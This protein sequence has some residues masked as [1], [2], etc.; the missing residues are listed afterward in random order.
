MTIKEAT[1]AVFWK[2]FKALDKTERSELAKKILA[3]QEIYEDLVDHLLIEMSRREKGKDITLDEY[4][5]QRKR[6][7]RR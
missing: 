4:L 3:D 2:A 6:R 7:A 5:A 1:A